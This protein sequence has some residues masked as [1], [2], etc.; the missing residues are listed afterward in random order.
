MPTFKVPKSLAACADLLYTTKA[1]RLEV[2]KQVDELE[3]Q[4]IQLKE[5][6]INNLPK[7]QA[8]G[9]AGKLA[10]VTLVQ[11]T[12][13]QVQDWDKFYAYVKK[14]GAFEMLQRRLSDAAIQERWDNKKQVPGVEPFKVTTVSVNKV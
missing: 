11:K 12:K 9:V 14:N 4:E 8:T 5:Y 1:R 2:Q 3:K 6:I 13:P 10:R 7:S